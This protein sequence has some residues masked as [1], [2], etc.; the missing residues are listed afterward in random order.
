MV[1]NTAMRNS[2]LALRMCLKTKSGKFELPLAHTRSRMM[3]ADPI[4]AARVFYRMMNKFFEIIVRWPLDQFTG[5]RMY[6]DRLLQ[7]NNDQYI[8]VFGFARAV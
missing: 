6:V 5:R 7:Q 8:G 2:K 1:H 4:A 3:A